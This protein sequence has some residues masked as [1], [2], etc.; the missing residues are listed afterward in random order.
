MVD[1]F[2]GIPD[3][4]I[5]STLQ[6]IRENLDKVGLFGGHTLRKHTDIQ[7]MVL[8][9]RLTKEDIRYATS[10]WD[11]NVA[12]AVASGLMR[13][14]YDSDIVFWLKNSS[15]D[16]EKVADELQMTAPEGYGFDCR[17]ISISNK[18][19]EQWIQQFEEKLGKEHLPELFRMLLLAGPKVEH[20]LKANEIAT[21]E[22]WICKMN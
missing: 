13:K 16:Y 17:K 2:T 8:K 7:L 22:N 6:T 18:I 20:Q 12:A 10:Y 11:V 19:Q 3:E 21:E 5:E 1:L 9:N 14:F 4:L 15:N